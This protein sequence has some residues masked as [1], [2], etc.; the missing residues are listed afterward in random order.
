MQHT[1]LS[2]F[3]HVLLCFL[4]TS[5]PMKPFSSGKHCSDDETLGMEHPCLVRKSGFGGFLFWLAC[6]GGW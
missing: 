5:S 4:V 2:C 3:Y 6:L 1:C